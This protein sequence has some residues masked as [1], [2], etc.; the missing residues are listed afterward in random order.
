MSNRDSLISTLSA[1][2]RLIDSRTH[3]YRALVTPDGRKVRRIFRGSFS[4]THRPKNSGHQKETL[5]E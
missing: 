3:V 5:D 1:I 4:N 2:K